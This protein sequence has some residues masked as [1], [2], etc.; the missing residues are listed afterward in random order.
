M[1]AIAGGF[2]MN[3]KTRLDKIEKDLFQYNRSNIEIL[4][5]LA[6]IETKLDYIQKN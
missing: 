6:R 4:D 3:T 2:F 5:R 1:S